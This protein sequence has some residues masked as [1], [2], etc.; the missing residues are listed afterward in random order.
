M[1]FLFQ[2]TAG[3]FPWGCD[4]HRVVP[5]HSSR[6]LGE[7]GLVDCQCNCGSGPGH[8]LHDDEMR[9]CGFEA[10]D[11]GPEESA[12]Y[13]VV[14]RAGR[15]RGFFVFLMIRKDIAA[16]DLGGMKGAQ[17]AGDARLGDNEAPAGQLFKNLPL[18]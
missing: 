2:A 13:R 18:S 14:G 9:T 8:G 12:K 10:K 6:D 1:E 5:R 16:V 11:G 15:G 3:L 4:E 17:V 7:R